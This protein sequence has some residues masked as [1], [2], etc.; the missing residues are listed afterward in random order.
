MV[1]VG[2]ILAVAILA[3]PL[4]TAMLPAGPGP[5]PC[6]P[7]GTLSAQSSPVTFN[8]SG[9]PAGALWTVR[10]LH[11]G[12]N[13]TWFLQN[14]TTA[15]L[16]VDV[17]QGGYNY[18]VENVT[19]SATLYRA[20][21][22]TGC[23][24]VG[25]S[26]LTVPVSFVAQPLVNLT[27]EESGLPVG[28]GW[29]VSLQGPS[30][31]EAIGASGAAITFQVPEETYDFLVQNVSN[32]VSS[33]AASPSTGQVVV[34]ATPQTVRVVYTPVPTYPVTFS[35]TGLPGGVD[36][37]AGI[38]YSTGAGYG[39]G[40]QAP[41]FTYDLPN[42]SYPFIVQN[43]SNGS[44]LYAPTPAQG[45]IVVAGSAVTV[46][47]VYALVVTYNASFVETGLPNG[48]LWNVVVSSPA[49]GNQSYTGGLVGDTVSFDLLPAG[50]YTFSVLAPTGYTAG[51]ATGD[52]DLEG[53][54]ATIG[55][56]F[57]S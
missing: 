33:F 46:P 26:G 18:T 55:I 57:S 1:V 27:F 32:S 51:P 4:A 45:T 7:F 36:W 54:D 13:Y 24:T 5:A 42:G 31:R 40:Q 11:N 53:T 3:V 8:E 21:P 17:P 37:G 43:A 50:R 44:V 39:F 38:Q 14:S 28:F 41:E 22:G 23:I 35:E 2:S 48:T 20:E 6:V 12:T 29:G 16:S 47:I 30:Y 9:L 34:N 25:A 19:A 56:S 49:L 15:T 52:F 10:L